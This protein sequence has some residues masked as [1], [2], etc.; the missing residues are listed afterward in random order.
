MNV[1][2]R[3][4]LVG[5]AL[6]LLIGNVAYY[7]YSNWG[8]ITVRAKDEPLRK[9][10]R[11]IERQGNIT[12][13]T[14]LDPQT[15]V[16]MHV[17]KVPLTEALETLATVTDS[18]WRLNFLIAPKKS[19]LR[20]ALAEL[21][22]GG[23]SESWKTVY[24]P[25]PPFFQSETGAIPDPR[26]DLWNVKSESGNSLENYVEQ[27]ARSVNAA[28]T[29]PSDWTPAV[30]RVPRNGAVTDVVPKL[31]K[32]AGGKTQAFFFLAK[33][34]RRFAEGERPPQNQQWQRGPVAFTGFVERV[35]RQIEQLPPEE[36]PAA[37]AR[38]EQMRTF[39]EEVRDLPPEQRR[40]R[41]RER[42]NDPEIQAQFEE[43][44]SMRDARRT[45]QQ[46]LQRYKRY[47][48]RKRQMQQR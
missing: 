9:V 37:Q 12:L 45:P 11:K 18:R 31:A 13:K 2:Q 44:R 27:G 35:A 3:N 10:I 5:A 23:N 41:M 48:E 4:L 36:R 21:Q 32:Y 29:I 25:L 17:V 20:V 43:R 7:V 24:Y 15:P 39:W 16:T 28:F 30:K 47:I 8:L 26:D 14:N 38:M 34:E 42:L 1:N 40:E 19:R 33:A 46:R 22:A 6:A